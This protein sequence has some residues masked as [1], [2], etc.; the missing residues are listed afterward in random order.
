M[1]L[2]LPLSATLLV[3]TL[4]PSSPT[5]LLPIPMLPTP[6]PQ[7]PQTHAST[8]RSVLGG[9]AA[10]STLALFPTAPAFAAGT[11]IFK[12]AAG[13]LEGTTIFITGANTGLGLE[14]AKRLAAAGGSV[15]VSA[16]S[17][18][19][20]DAAAKAV[21][22]KTVGVELDLADLK[23]VKSLPQ[24]LEAALGGTPTIDVLLNN[25][26]VM[27]V[28]E[29][30][31]TADGFEKTVGINHL[32]HYALVAALMP[33]LRRAKMGCRIVTVSSDAHRFADEKSLSEALN[34]RLDPTSYGLGGWG[35]YGIS[36][37]ANVLFTVELQ[38]RF[39]EA[40]VR[41]SAV[42]L[43]PGVVQTDLA[44]YVTGGIGAAD[45]HPTDVPPPT[46]LGAF[47]KENV[48]DKALLTVDRGANT[49]VYLAAAADTDGDRTR[50]GGLYFDDM[51]AVKPAEASQDG[52]LARRL[53]DLSEQLT[54]ATIVI[55]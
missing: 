24:R 10:A 13:S 32:G 39:E 6:K 50:R 46:G 26:G 5:A 35:A 17:Q 23:S 42:T 37:A 53:W 4:K 8:R 9:A 43:H 3:P 40:G 47:F 36:K 52:A 30:V 44:R 18:S 49:Q 16:R 51:K 20:A 22:G 54:G 34:A 55:Q 29:R 38:R 7:S 14:S 15:V 41:G 27:A 12:P 45:A 11:S 33:S 31:S 1:M 19:K 2:G 21:G 48:L 25:A 28:P